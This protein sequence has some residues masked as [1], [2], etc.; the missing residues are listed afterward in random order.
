[1]CDNGR[2]VSMTTFI[3]TPTSC[4]TGFRKTC[5]SVRRSGPSSENPTRS[6]TVIKQALKHDGPVVIDLWWNVKKVFIQWCRWV[7]NNQYD[8]SMMENRHVISVLVENK[9]GVLAR[10]SGMF[11]G[12]AS[13]FILWLS[14][15]ARILSFPV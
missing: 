14:L 5:R 3:P 9:P 2:N 15:Q 8:I 11:S 7:I 1:M 6:G 12:R 4:N 13:T 10:V